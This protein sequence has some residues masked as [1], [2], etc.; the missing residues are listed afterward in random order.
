MIKIN[1]KKDYRDEFI[2][3]FCNQLGMKYQRKVNQSK[4]K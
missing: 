1:W 2:C 3:T 4:S